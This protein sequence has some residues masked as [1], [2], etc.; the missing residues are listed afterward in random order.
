MKTIRLRSRINKEGFLRIQ[1]PGHH[2]EDVELLVI[3]Q[4]VQTGQQRQWSQR[5]LALSGAWQGEPLARA[6]QETQP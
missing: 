6:H 1:L 5:F 2:D 4:P 3:Y